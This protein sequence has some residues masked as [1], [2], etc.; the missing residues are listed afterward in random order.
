MGGEQRATEM[1]MGWKEV[2]KPGEQLR[3]KTD[4][5]RLLASLILENSQPLNASL[6]HIVIMLNSGDRDHTTEQTVFFHS[7]HCRV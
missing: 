1:V 4:H 3:Y 7:E 2:G 5:K 6:D